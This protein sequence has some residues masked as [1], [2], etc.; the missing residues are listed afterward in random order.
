MQN[1]KLQ[2]RIQR[3][4]WDAAAEI[5]H[6]NWQDK[7][8]PVHQAMFDMAGLK[9]ADRVLE[10]ACGSGLAT[11]Q[12][13]NIVGDNGHVFAT[14][15]S[16]EMISI[17]NTT[18]ARMG[19]KNITTRRTG[20][21]DSETVDTGEFDAALCALGLMYFPQPELAL[22]NMWQALKPGGRA[23][24]VVWGQRNKCRWAELFPIVDEFVESD[25]CP[26]FFSLGFGEALSQLYKSQG[27]ES[28]DTR[29][30]EIRL[31]FADEQEIFAAFIDGGPVALAVKRFNR[32]TRHK[33]EMAFLDSVI[34]FKNNNK[35]SIPTEYVVVSGIK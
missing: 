9:P 8:L 13:A 23:T 7:L 35:F 31:D 27:F 25:V 30:V 24:S 11:T 12:V 33:V 17:L 28:V 21:E 34:D 4:G 18:I 16:V 19:L 2:R 20:A 14:D 3:Y 29:R 15:I 10:I 5:Y 6:T 32:D 26:L 1:A 22:G